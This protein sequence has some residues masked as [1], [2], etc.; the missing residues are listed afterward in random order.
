M[1]YITDRK[2]QLLLQAFEKSA[3]IIDLHGQGYGAMS[4]ALKSET[5]RYGVRAVLKAN[6]LNSRTRDGCKG[7]YVEQAGK[8]SSKILAL[9]AKGYCPASIASMTKTSLYGVRWVLEENG[10]TSNRRKDVTPVDVLKAQ[11]KKRAKRMNAEVLAEYKSGKSI[12]EIA[13]QYGVT[14]ERIRQ[15]LTRM[16]AKMRAPGFQKLTEREVKQIKKLLAASVLP[17][18]IAAKF[19]V[20]V[21]CVK[22]IGTGRTWKWVKV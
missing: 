18:D 13:K 1:K 16:G 20:T 9:H 12:A 21:C 7:R 14:F 3:Q 17:S 4:I 2:K 15:R 22:G 10:L 8:K 5:S 19:G 6:G 11:V